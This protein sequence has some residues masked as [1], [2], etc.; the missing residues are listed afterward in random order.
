[1]YASTD[2]YGLTFWYPA[3]DTVVGR[4]LRETGEF[5]R[6]ELEFLEA[7]LTGMSPGLVLDVGA[8]IGAIGLPLARRFPQMS[9]RCFEPSPAVYS[10]LCTNI[11]T[12]G[13]DNAV[14]YSL[15]VGSAPRVIPFPAPSAASEINFG[16]VG[17]DVECNA[18][19]P[20]ILVAVDGLG[21]AD[22]RLAKIDVQGHDLAVLQGGAR[23]WRASLPVVF[24]EGGP[25]QKTAQG[26]RLLRDLGYR[27]YWM[28]SPFLTPGNAKGHPVGTD[29]WAGDPN[30]VA[31]PLART[32]P[33]PL[34]E[35]G[36]D[37]EDWRSRIAEIFA[38]LERYR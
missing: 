21:L 4:C 14:P 27:C 31:I 3:R 7:C 18:T 5:A 17:L 23:T 9:V 29:P 22:V 38:G 35:I 12:N 15:A 19:S 20:T 13:I 37:D 33:W 32:C 1:M 34:P 26:I 10:A 36:A 24:F 16:A 6:I 2:A 25:D 8:N 28:Y 30:V 11:V